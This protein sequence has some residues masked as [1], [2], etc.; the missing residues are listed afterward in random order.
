MLY[1][2]FRLVESEQVCVICV[3]ADAG[4]CSPVNT[5]SCGVQ[6]REIGSSGAQVTSSFELLILVYEI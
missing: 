3:H 6:N 1:S 2:I 4:I 5:G